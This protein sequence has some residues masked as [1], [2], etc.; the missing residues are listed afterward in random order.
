[1]DGK[2]GGCDLN[3]GVRRGL[4]EGMIQL[5]TWSLGFEHSRQGERASPKVGARKT[6]SEQDSQGRSGVSVSWACL[7]TVLQPV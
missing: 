5:A 3:T 6:W 2:D 1:M 4:I 7:N